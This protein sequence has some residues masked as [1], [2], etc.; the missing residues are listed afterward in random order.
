MK[1]LTVVG[2][3]PEAVKLAPVVRELQRRADDGI[4]AVL[5]VTGQHRQMLDPVLRLFDLVP[6]HELNVMMQGRSL[7]GLGAT[8]LHAIEPVLHSERPDWVLV[9]GDTTT[10]AAAALAAAWARCRV[11]HVE[12]GLRTYD[13]A[14]PFPEEINRRVAGVV[15]D[16]HFAPT[17][18]ARANLLQ[19]H[20]PPESVLVTGNP[21]IDALHCVAALPEPPGL[22]HL[23]PWLTRPSPFSPRLILVTAHRRENLGTPLENICLALRDLAG[24][25]GERLRILYPVH[26]NPQVQDTA[27]RLLDGVS[28]VTLCDP[29]D[30]ATLVHVMKRADLILTDS[31]GLQEEAPSLGKPVLVLR[32]ATE[33]PEAIEAGTAKL[34]GTD[35]TQIVAEVNRLIGDP[36]TYAAMARAV[37]PY[38]DGHAAERIVA[39]LL[40]L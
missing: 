22:A 21:G 10:V 28:G 26:L 32:D 7:A 30:Y 1:V 13:R 15:A 29:L 5:C 27:Y 16:F 24:H 38:G 9:Q 6:H 39:T 33:R 8:I 25:W 36:A 3:R 20:V 14:H 31:G 23:L 11:G 18:R 19:E 4:D 35:R 40:K 12:A 34:I 37:S 17:A 2:T